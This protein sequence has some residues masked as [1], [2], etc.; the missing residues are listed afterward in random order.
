MVDHEEDYSSDLETQSNPRRTWVKIL[1]LCAAMGGAYGAAI[2]A[3]IATP[4][5]AAKLIGIVAGV[6][7]AICAFPGLRYGSFFGHVNRLRFGRLFVGTVA[8][9][10]GAILGGLLGI[11]TTMPLG[12][13]SGAIGG[14]FFGRFISQR[15]Y[16]FHYEL[17]GVFMGACI[18]AVV[19][20]LRQ[21]E[22]AALPGASWGLG[23]GAIIGPLLFLLFIGTLYSLPRRA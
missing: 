17:L 22:T 14:W 1:A 9:V 2:G 11:V 13:L 7:A 21:D 8:T 19:L 10:L 15:D 23:I 20:T 6:V 4:D 16:R 18:G 5:G 3:I 12:A